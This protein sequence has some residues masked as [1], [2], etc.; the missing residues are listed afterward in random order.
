MVGSD[1]QH[2]G[3]VDKVRGARVILTKNDQDAGG[4][5]H[6]FPSSWLQSVDGGK[7][8]LSKTAADAKAAWKDEERKGAMFSGSDD[9]HSGQPSGRQQAAGQQ[10]AQAGQQDAGKQTGSDDKGGLN[11]SFSGT[12]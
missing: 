6:S 4:H 3:T 8:T 9:Q 10:T 12:Y 7:V 11:R 5:H 1:G 2:V